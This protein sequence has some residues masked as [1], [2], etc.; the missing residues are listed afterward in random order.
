MLKSGGGVRMFRRWGGRLRTPLSR[1][2]RKLHAVS[3]RE[4]DYLVAEVV[5]LRGLMP[6]L[7]R[8]GASRQ[9]SAPDRAELGTHLRRVSILS[10][11][12]LITLVPGTLVVLPLLVWWRNRGRA[13][14]AAVA[15]PPR[16]D[17]E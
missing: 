4:R 2:V 12:L 8:S 6:L 11:Y 9:I 16:Q 17:A 10:S 3:G 1:A 7:R 14:A 13:R 15:M 5:Q